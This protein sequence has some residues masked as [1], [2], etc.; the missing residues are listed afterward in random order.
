MTTNI[1][2]LPL[3]E[4]IDIELK[5]EKSILKNNYK[6]YRELKNKDFMSLR[7]LERLLH[8]KNDCP[9]DDM[10]DR[11]KK[12]FEMIFHSKNMRPK[13]YK[14]NYHQL[15]DNDEFELGVTIEEKTKKKN[16]LLP[17]NNVDAY[18]GNLLGLSLIH[19]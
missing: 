4:P 17:V 1:L 16:V 10:L 9:D 14:L 2:N 5:K 12:M 13:K 11:L 7:E 15:S 8:K 6:L 18:K 19:I 3:T